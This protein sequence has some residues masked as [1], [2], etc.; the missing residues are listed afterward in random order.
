[1]VA[2]AR[3]AFDLYISQFVVDEF[4]AGDPASA[5]ERLRVLKYLSLLDITPEVTQLTSEILACGK[6]PK[7][8]STEAAE[9][10]CGICLGHGSKHKVV[11]FVRKRESASLPVKKCIY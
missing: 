6:M 8:A 11:S 3:E 4:S 5:R 2:E 9:I 1:V 10:A 7:K